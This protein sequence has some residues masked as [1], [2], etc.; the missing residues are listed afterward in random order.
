MAQPGADDDDSGEKPH[1]ATPRKLEEARRKGDL[2]QSADLLATAALFG[3]LLL[4]LLPDGGVAV[5][6]GGIGLDLLEHPDAIG[7]A[8]LGGGTSV[9]LLLL[10]ALAGALA[11]VAMVP[12][13]AVV[14]ALVALRGLVLAPGKLVPKLSR[15][16]PLANARQKFGPGGLF[17]F[18]KSV[19]KLI[20]FCAV[21]LAFLSARLPRLMAMIAQG[22]GQVSSGLLWMTFEFM[23]LVALVMAL[24]GVLDF[25]FQ[26]FDHRRRQRMTHRELLDELKSSEGDPQLKQS[27]RA[28]AEAIASNRML[29]EVPRATVVIVNPTHYAVALRWDPAAGGAPLCV[30]KGTDEIAARIRELAEGA[31]VPVLS[32]PPTARALHALLRVGDEVRPEQYAPVAAAIRFAEAMRKRA[33]GAVPP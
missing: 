9:A 1:E 27:R 20:V 21:L 25:L 31:R 26:R 28:R 30:A 7:A 33:A 3:F 23:V 19:V 6:L 18:A 8:L 13:L 5:R 32:D 10:T 14:A 29:T 4:A 16:S 24:V 17:E 12:I 22:P 11:P 2:P 15:I